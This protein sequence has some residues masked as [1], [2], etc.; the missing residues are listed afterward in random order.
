MTLKRSTKPAAQ[1]Q[2]A[3]WLREVSSSKID[4]LVWTMLIC[5][6]IVLSSTT[7]FARTFNVLLIHGRL[8]NTH[9]KYGHFRTDQAGAWGLRPPTGGT[10]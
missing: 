5:F 10:A 7:A 3:L 8:H 1:S 2:I 4:L 9:E 6:T